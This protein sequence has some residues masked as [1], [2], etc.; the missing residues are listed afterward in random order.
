MLNPKE[1]IFNTPRPII[2]MLEIVFLGTGSSIPSRSRNLSSIWMRYEGNAFLFDCAEGTQR[3]LMSAK[4]SFM[5]IE[6]IF[7]THW[8]ADHWAGL[9]GLIQTM[10][11]E[12]RKKPLYIYGP[13]AERF[14][15][16]ILELSYWAPRFKVIPVTIPFEGDEITPLYKT[17]DFEIHSTPAKHSIPAVIYSLKERDKINV[18]IAKAQKN[19][20]LKQGPMIGKLKK[21]K[22]VVFKGKKIKLEDVALVKKGIKV[23]YTGDTQVCENL[24]KIAEGADILIH[25][26]TFES[27]KE[28]RMHAGAKQA[29]EV[30]KKAGVK[31]LILT[32]FSRRYVDVRPL[33]EQARKIFPNT[34]SAKDFMRVELKSTI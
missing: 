14:V 5:K 8:H 2:Y 19:Y 30:A 16:N 17:K 23:V 10:N 21:K 27:E 34:V 12:R 25:D 24:V 3:Q 13:E 31:K 11:L 4:L 28:T 29:A 26:S 7:I 9:I 18:D 22:Q 20:G 32:H 33:E 15:D 1:P 6:R